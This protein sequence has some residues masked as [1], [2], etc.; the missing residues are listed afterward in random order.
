MELLIDANILFSLMN[1]SSVTS[2]I[3]QERNFRLFAPKF[4]L[5]EL[6][7][8][9]GEC[10]K[11]S[12]L[13]KEA[14]QQRKVLIQSRLSFIDVQTYKSLLKRAIKLIPDLDD[15]PYLACALSQNLPLWSN[16]SHFKQQSL[17][18]VLTTRELLTL[19]PFE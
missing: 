3:F 4:I 16:D 18:P 11:K 19:L 15:V 1:P 17:I 9:E 10:Q 2:Q 6:D 7:E 13:S 5:S 8:H 12:H 14:F